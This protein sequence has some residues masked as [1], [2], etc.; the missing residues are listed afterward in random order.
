MVNIS[1]SDCAQLPSQEPSVYSLIFALTLKNSVPNGGAT[2]FPFGVLDDQFLF[3]CS[4]SDPFNN[5]C[6]IPTK[7]SSKP[8]PVNAGQVIFNRTSGSTSPNNT[9]TET[10]TVTAAATITATASSAVLASPLSCP[11]SSSSKDVA[12]G[13]GVGV[14]LGLAFLIALALLWIQRGRMQI[15]TKDVRTWEGKY[16]DS[17]N[18]KTSKLNGTEYQSPHQ[19]E[20][21]TP[22]EL[23]GQAAS[24]GRPDE[25]D[26]RQ[27]LQM[28]DKT[29]WT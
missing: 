13:A 15:L 28:E 8:F 18:T 6:L 10:V 24:S 2:M 27:V 16:Q 21:W 17:M 4:Q 23:D 5:T 29:R 22:N 9:N 7:G 25:I 12:I 3:C 11:S 26:G 19:L 14:P 1:F 20:G